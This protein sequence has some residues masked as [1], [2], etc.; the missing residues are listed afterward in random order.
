MNDSLNIF[1][2]ISFHGFTL[3]FTSGQKGLYFLQNH[4]AF[5]KPKSAQLKT[6]IL[7]SMDQFQV[8]VQTIAVLCLPTP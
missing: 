5:V 3:E 1:G 8:V 4:F 6:L 7:Y 2:T